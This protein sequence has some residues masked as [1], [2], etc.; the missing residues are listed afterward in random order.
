MNTIYIGAGNRKLGLQQFTIYREKPVELIKI[1]SK[2]ISLIEKLFVPVDE[3]AEKEQELYK[4]ESLIYKVS[5]EIGRLR[6]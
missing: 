4:P 2:K 6:D 3:F 5:E 1:L